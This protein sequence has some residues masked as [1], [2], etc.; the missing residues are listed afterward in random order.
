MRYGYKANYSSSVKRILEN[1]DKSRALAAAIQEIRNDPSKRS[2]D[3]DGGRVRTDPPSRTK[4]SE[5]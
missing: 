2:A 4:A 1:P 3:L 5:R